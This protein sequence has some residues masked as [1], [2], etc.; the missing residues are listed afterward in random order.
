MNLIAEKIENPISPKVSI[1]VPVFNPGDLLYKCLNSITNQ[2]LHEI[3]I[4]CV[5]DGSTDDSL[6][7][8]N[9][10]SKRDTRFKIFHQK[11]K[12]AGFAR[13]KGIDESNGEFIIFVDSDDWIDKYMCEKLYNHAIKLNSDLVIFDSLW[14]TLDGTDPFS[15]F[16]DD[17]FQEDFNEYTFDY[18]FIKTRLMVASYGVIWSRFYKSSFIKENN[19]RFPK[20]KIY[21]DVEFCFKTAL[22]AKSISYYPEMFY[23]YIRLGQ[24]SLQ[25]SF[26]EGKDEL[27][28]FDVLRGLYNFLNDYNFLEELR[29]D[30]INYCIF[31]SFGKLKNIDVKFQSSFLE[32]WKSFFNI[33]KPT[34]EELN[35]LRSTNL[36][37]YNSITVN[38]IPL[39]QGIINNNYDMVNAKLL[40]F[41]LTDAIENLKT[42]PEDS[43][44]DYYQSLRDY[45]GNYEVNLVMLNKLPPQVYDLYLSILNFETYYTFDLLSED[46][47]S[48]TFEF[49]DILW[50]DVNN[51]KEIGD[52]ALFNEEYGNLD[53]IDDYKQLKVIVQDPI[54]VR[55]FSSVFE[56]DLEIT[57]EVKVT[58]YANIGLSSYN[59]VQKFSSI[60]I[61]NK[62]WLF[63]RFIY[64]NKSVFA[65]IS[66]NGIDW[67]DISL[68][69]DN[70]DEDKCQFQFNCGYSNA[71]DKRILMR[72]LKIFKI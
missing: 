42:L 25:T 17:E 66:S 20:H 34:T 43:K 59:N 37:W 54:V 48:K 11:N 57:V 28:W 24:P 23:N 38:Y 61:L 26:R 12:G 29:L 8:L 72:N 6:E 22:L 70:L 1:I 13:N 46:S 35:L 32:G 21:N 36:T 18:H 7:I 49:K 55:C 15:Y 3:E 16:S 56:G 69:E 27:V 31:Y 10:Y 65:Y 14:H 39:Y 60:R 62:D 64:L 53:V 4:I 45:V 47:I 58:D 40:E 5:D 51:V 19:I 63:Y 67:K 50:Y 41:K 68:T 2:S 33:L 71:S 52:Y 30:F 44:N 9:D